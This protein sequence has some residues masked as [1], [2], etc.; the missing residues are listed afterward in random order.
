[1]FNSS[2]EFIDFMKALIDNI[3]LSIKPSIENKI[4]IEFTVE[5]LYKQN[6]IKIDLVQK[7]VNFE[8]ISQDL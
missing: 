6:I 1:M 8:L 7:K 5:Y 2:I 4:S 3:K